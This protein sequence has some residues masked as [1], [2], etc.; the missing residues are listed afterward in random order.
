MNFQSDYTGSLF[1]HQ[2][3]VATS[4]QLIYDINI[5]HSNHHPPVQWS[6]DRN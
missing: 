5:A 3:L 2:L 6:S 4:C 1:I